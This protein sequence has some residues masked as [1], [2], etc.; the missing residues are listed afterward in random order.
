MKKLMIVDDSRVIRNRIQRALNDFSL[1][2][3]ASA[4]DGVEA[5]T[6]A[7]Q[8][9]PDVVTMDLTMPEMNGIECIEEILKI[10]PDMLILVVS[11]LADKATAIEALK[12][13]AHGFLCK[14]FTEQE[15]TDALAELI[16]GAGHA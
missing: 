14:P 7:E 12:R 8:T 13:G 9:R 15:L 10:K 6:L 1:D 2:V 4:R 3:V 11:A 16:R 5:V